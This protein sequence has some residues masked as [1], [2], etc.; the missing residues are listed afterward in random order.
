METLNLVQGTDE[1]LEVR[2]N[3][4][5]AS[6]ASAMMDCSKFMSRNQL[7]AL[8][9]GWQSSPD[10]SFKAKLF[11]DGHQSESQ[12]R[13][14]LEIDT[15]DEFPPVTGKTTIDGLQLFASFDG[16]NSERLPWEHKLWNKT[17]AENVKNL[18]LEPL[19]FWQLEH[20]MLV[21][22][23][24]QCLFTVSDGTDVSRETMVYMS[25][26]ERRKELIAGWKQFDLDL[27]NYVIKAKVVQVTAQNA[28]SFPIV[29]YEVQGTNLISN[30]SD[31][32]VVIKERATAE[33]S[34]VL[35]SDQD[36]ADKDLLNKA[37]KKSRTDL[38]NMVDNAQN[39][40]ISYSE[41]AN[42]AKEVD[43]VLQKM[44]SHGERQVKDGKEIKKKAIIDSAFNKYSL[45]VTGI[46]ELIKPLSIY[47]FN[48]YDPSWTMATKN[49]RTLESVQNAVDTELSKA[50]QSINEIYPSILANLATLRADA[51]DFKFLFMDVQ[52]LASMN[53]EG[54]QATIKT[55]ISEHKDS[56]KIRLEEEREKIREVES[57]K[58]KVKA[59]ERQD[60]IVEANRIADEA[61]QQAE[62]KAKEKRERE[63]R[64]RLEAAETTRIE[65]AK[66]K[67]AADQ[68]VIDAKAAVETEK[69]LAKESSEQAERDKQKAIQDVQ[70]RAEKDARELAQKQA[71]EKAKK[72]S[73][74]LLRKA[75]EKKKSDNKRHQASVNNKILA[76]LIELGI[77]K[78]TG[79]NLIRQ[80]AL[81]QIPG[82]LINY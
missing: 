5:T 79:K 23:A 57:E 80:I 10:S 33:M 19:Y 47:D 27:S 43:S 75:E 24:D 30:I 16:M 68:A 52:N 73:D 21:A 11:L 78:E 76:K 20:Q 55:R 46:N 63:E 14:L 4:F 77:E 62:L 53:P 15:M 60:Q 25:V 45:F 58:A 66:E 39:E 7:L 35:E 37:V 2:L 70:D 41:F 65:S 61:D 49:K 28:E 59:E 64:I 71:Q 50:Q 3:H 34:R 67:A 40:F 18:I 36:F 72:E 26:P 38:K 74:E 9:K 51:V 12:A 81:N 6:E 42:V 8:K 32:L 56:E 13:L 1:W 31:C 44:Q 82:L 48:V 22:G 69:R 54:L 29:T 17:L